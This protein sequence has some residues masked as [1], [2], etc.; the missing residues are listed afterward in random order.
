MA[1]LSAGQSHKLN[2]SSCLELAQ[3]RNEARP[4]AEAALTLAEAQY[5][6][7]MAAYWPQVNGQLGAQL[8]NDDLNF[9]MPD[10]NVPVSGMQLQTPAFALKTPTTMVTLPANA[11]G[12]GFPP[13]AV[14]IPIPSQNVT[15]PSQTATLPDMNFQVPSQEV[16]LMDRAMGSAGVDMKWL[17]LDGGGRK[18]Q[19]DQ[20]KAGIKAAEQEVRRSG[21]EIARDVTRYYYG[22]VLCR[23]LLSV[24]RDT[25]SRMLETLKFTEQLYKGGSEKVLK[26]DYLRN[27][28]MVETLDGMIRAMEGNRDLADCALTFAMGMDWQER[29]EPADLD[30]PVTSD[31]VL[32]SLVADA[33]SFSPDWKKLEAGLEAAERGV[34]VA[35]SG[36]MPRLAFSGNLHTIQTGSDGTGIASD[37][38][39]NGWAVGFG[40]E[41]PIWDGMLTKNRVAEARAR[42]DMLKHQR[43]HLQ[44]GLALQV[45]AAFIR[46]QS[47]SA[48]H[49]SAGQA[50]AS[51]R[52][53]RELS[54]KAYAVDMIETDKVFQ[55][56]MMEA[57]M[58]ARWLKSAGDHLTAR[59]ELDYVAGRSMTNF[60]TIAP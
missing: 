24:A 44:Q 40:I 9:I 8:R 21:L 5:R 51:A 27:K 32:R 1:A 30:L 52:E 18:A 17:L 58:E 11:L 23:R 39:R 2:L 26:T 28:V 54:N 56:Q 20:A 35:K 43:V 60:L 14:Q 46:M 6:Q 12:P 13:K 55:S 16:K 59:A 45:K 38:N 53:N 19:K 37:S 29:V 22:S 7:A 36:H 10:M 41:L 47:A 49:G 57:L 34:G 42:L 33:Y 15:I 25:H 50:L 3:N 31:G 48:E 4:V